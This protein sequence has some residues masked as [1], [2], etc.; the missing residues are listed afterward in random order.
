MAPTGPKV[1]EKR[2]GTSRKFYASLSNTHS[3]LFCYIKRLIPAK[4]DT[5][6]KKPAE[7]IYFP[8]KIKYRPGSTGFP[9]TTG[10][11]YP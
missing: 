6:T 11:A 7:F 10:L 8:K 4:P 3:P 1:G 9:L 5:T 2:P